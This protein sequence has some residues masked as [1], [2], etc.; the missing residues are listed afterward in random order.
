MISLP[1]KVLICL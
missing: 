1:N